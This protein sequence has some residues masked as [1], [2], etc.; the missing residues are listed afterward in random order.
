MCH[1]PAW[2][3]LTEGEL[4]RCSQHA[5][6]CRLDAVHSLVDVL[7]AQGKVPKAAAD[8]VGVLAVV[9]GQLQGKVLLLWARGQEG[10][11]V[12]LLHM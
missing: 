2:K 10:V 4:C 12:L 1:A 5:P 9:V 8:V 11:C 7:H 6:T 3:V